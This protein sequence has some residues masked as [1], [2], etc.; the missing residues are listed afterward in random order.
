MLSPTEVH[1][2]STV[3]ALLV[4]LAAAT[5]ACRPAPESAPATTAPVATGAP[6]V[7]APAP[8][9]APQLPPPRSEREAQARA[10]VNELRTRLQQAL[11]AA[12]QRGPDEAIAACRDQAPKL[13]AEIS[14]KGIRVGRTSHRLRNPANAPEPWLGAL[15]PAFVAGTVQEPSLSAALP[16]GSLGY[17]EPIKT[18]AL[19]LTC[20]GAQVAEPLRTKIAELYPQDQA[21]GFAEGDF[22]GLFWALVPPESEQAPGIVPAAPATAPGAGGSGT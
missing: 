9:A 13:A 22:R 8:P 16:D 1:V 17:V 5:V 12:L 4:M 3:R 11:Q 10:A 19:C 14:A 20:H 21:M 15:L 6:A 18:G 7:V 2:R